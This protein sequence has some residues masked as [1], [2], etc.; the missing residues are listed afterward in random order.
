MKF[1]I[2]IGKVDRYILLPIIGGLIR[3]VFRFILYIDNQSLSKHPLIISIFSSLGM[4]LSIILLIIHK[5]RIKNNKKKFE[6][7]NK[8]RTGFIELEY[9]DQL[10]DIIYDKNK[11]FLFS[12]AL[13]I[14]QTILSVTILIDVKQNMWIFDI[15]II[16]VIS[17]FIF[18]KK[19]FLHH[20][21]SIILIIIIGIIL[22]VIGGNYS[23]IDN[24]KEWFKIIIKIF[25]EIII[26]LMVIINEYTIEKK[27]VSAYELCFYQ[28]FL[29][30]IFYIIL[31]LILFCLH[32]VDYLKDYL[33]SFNFFFTNN[34]D[35]KIMIPF[36]IIML[37][38]FSFNIC[39]FLTIE[40]ISLYH[41]MIL[42][43]ISE[44]LPFIDY[45]VNYGKKEIKTIIMIVGF[46]FIFFM[47]LIFNETIEIN[48]CGMEKNTKKNISLR[49]K[50]EIDAINEY[51]EE[52]EEEKE[53]EKEEEEEDENEGNQ[54][55]ER[56]KLNDEKE[57]NNN[58]SI[59]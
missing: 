2:S 1:I 3:L 51:K 43:I 46:I 32:T 31:E 54:F 11:Y 42:I 30:F 13:D 34:T 10:E 7:E 15:L 47:A 26:S 48:C 50:L 36:F 35:P 56:K 8:K 16:S 12:S 19:L 23:K 21:V 44:L 57:D 52:E 33:D 45:I 4:T 9:N 55:S 24:L 59:N 49:A 38:S 6:K 40:K 14:I 41:T 39:F 25:N 37:L 53:E 17:Y 28:G 58:N 29:T 22:D 20:Y 5:K 18:R 27:F